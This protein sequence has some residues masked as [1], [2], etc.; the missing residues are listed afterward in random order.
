LRNRWI[1]SMRLDGILGSWLDRLTDAALAWREARRAE[2]RLVLSQEDGSFVLRP[3]PAPDGPALAEV[4]IASASPRTLPP[5]L[6]RASAVLVLDPD[7]TV[8]R[9]ISVP[10]QG[11]AFLDGIVRNQL[12]RLSPWPPET[13]AHGYRV[14][15]DVSGAS[16]PIE[17]VIAARAAVEAAKDAAAWLGLAIDAVAARVGPGPLVVLWTREAAS[18]ELRQGVRRRIGL[19][20][21][22]AFGA[23][24]ALIVWN[25]VCLN[26]DRQEA[27]ETAAQTAALRQRFQRGRAAAGPASSPA[28]RAWAQKEATPAAVVV[29]EALSRALPDDAHLTEL[30]LEGTQL[31]VMGLSADPPA[32]IGRLDPSPYFAEVRFAAPTTRG[33]DAA[34]RFQIEARVKPRL[35]VE[36]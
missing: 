28:E 5:G 14:A 26:L 19:A 23:M 25:V 18:A 31:R 34:Y 30:R 22:G 3:A 9:R 8:V 35:S 1:A 24:A 10:T 7:E 17:V 20:L 13:A 4:P 21:G 36:D 15:P 32:L 2:R 12:D 6:A 33:S 11:R 16:L 29:L 27:E